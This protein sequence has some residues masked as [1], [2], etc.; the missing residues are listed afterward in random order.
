MRRSALAF[1]NLD[2]FPYPDKSPD[3][4]RTRDGVGSETYLEFAT[5]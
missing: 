5:P 3:G 1:L 4:V 2:N